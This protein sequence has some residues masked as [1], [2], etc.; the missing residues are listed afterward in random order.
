MPCNALSRVQDVSPVSFVLSRRNPALWITP[1]VAG[2]RCRVRL[3]DRQFPSDPVTHRSVLAGQIRCLAKTR[4]DSVDYVQEFRGRVPPLGY[5]C[6][7]HKLSVIPT[8]AE[9]VRHIFRR[10]AVLGSMR[11]QQ[12]LEQ[13]GVRR[14]S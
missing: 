14:Q 2:R 8:E 13:A 4:T 11:L 7:D 9:T 1:F 6:R 3:A 5:A 10:Y 12:Q